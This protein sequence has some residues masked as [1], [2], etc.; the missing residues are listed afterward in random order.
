MIKNHNK[1]QLDTNISG[2]DMLLHKN[3]E[4]KN[5]FR[6]NNLFTLMNAGFFS[7]EEKKEK[8]LGYF[9]IWS[10]YFQKMILLR[11]A[12]CEDPIFTPIF[13]QHLD[14]EYGHD[15]DLLSGRKIKKIESDPILEA[16]SHW[17]FSKMLSFPP[18][19]QLVLVNLCVEASAN[20]FYEHAI[21]SIDTQGNIAYFQEHKNLDIEHE[22]IGCYLLLNLGQEHYERLFLVQE[23]GWTMIETLMCRLAELSVSKESDLKSLAYF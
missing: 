9:Q 7:S 19:D 14:E 4:F 13:K 22:I 10:T 5:K 3:E 6:N 16:I 11:S 8:F 17:F 12:L 15:R 18:T 20:I 23:K 21:P 1:K 2:F